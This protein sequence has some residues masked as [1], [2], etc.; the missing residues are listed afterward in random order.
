MYSIDAPVNT[1]NYF[2]IVPTSTFT[3]QSL[4]AFEKK[5]VLN[6]LQGVVGSRK[7]H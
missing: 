4:V 1:L 3:V 6:T 5:K 2:T 7:N